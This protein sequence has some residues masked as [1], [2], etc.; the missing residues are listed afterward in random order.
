MLGI[1]PSLGGSFS[2]LHLDA[3]HQHRAL[4]SRWVAARWRAIL[5]LVGVRATDALGTGRL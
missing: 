1:V 2:L 4:S 5:E 3:S